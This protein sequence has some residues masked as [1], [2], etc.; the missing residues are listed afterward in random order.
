MNRIHELDALRGIA[1]YGILLVNIFVFHAPYSYYA[2]FYGAFEGIQSTA[3][4]L[5]VN[6]AAGKFL[7]I[8][9]LL[10]GYGFQLQRH[11][12]KN[13]FTTYYFRKMTI[14]LMFGI[15][16]ILFFWFGDILAFYALLGILMLLLIQLPQRALLPIGILL[17]LF[18]PLY[19][20]GNVIWGWP[21]IGM[22]KPLEM[23]EFIESFQGGSYS[24]IFG[25]RMKE[26]T[27]YIPENLV[28][29]VPKTL[30]LFLIGYYCAA[31]KFTKHL[32]QHASHYFIGV[33]LVFVACVFWTIFK[34]DFFGRFNLEEM[35]FMRPVLIAINIFFE[36]ALGMSY[37]VGFLLFFQSFR[38]MSNILGTAGRMAL[39]NYIAQSLVCVFLFYGY[40]FGFYGKLKPTDLLLIGTLI[41]LFNLFFSWLYLRYY[42]QGPL[43]YLWRR[44]TVHKLRLTKPKLH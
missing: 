35:P 10:F 40:G 9:A 27:A 37:T 3:V 39:T 15:I 30:G 33:A 32:K 42:Q 23:N 38:R 31:K 5:V 14:L 19:Y 34:Q 16:H 20:L 41:F 36:S 43:E 8:F 6:F 28:W 18:S 1:L 25:I 11:S 26:F 44:M 24:E 29:V 7:F 21:M 2:E 13:E 12:R 17:V 4:N 22:I